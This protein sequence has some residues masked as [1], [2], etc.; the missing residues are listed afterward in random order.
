MKKYNKSTGLQTVII[1]STQFS[2]IFEGKKPASLIY[3]AEYS[4]DDE[5]YVSSFEANLIDETASQT[6][7]WDC[8]LGYEE[9]F[10]IKVTILGSKEDISEY[11]DHLTKLITDEIVRRAGRKPESSFWD[12]M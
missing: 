1:L 12:R 8:V 7:F 4:G 3:T 2:N 10:S 6:D 5:V 11:Q 9:S